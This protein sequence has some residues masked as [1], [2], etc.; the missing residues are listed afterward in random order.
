MDGQEL[1]V[2]GEERR[3]A[4]TSIAPDVGISASGGRLTFVYYGSALLTG[5]HNDIA[6]AD[7]LVGCRIVEQ[8]AAPGSPHAT[9][10]GLKWWFRH[11]D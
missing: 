5:V 1:W 6:G 7:R 10:R 8:R 11:L 3:E 4:S 9:T 2:K